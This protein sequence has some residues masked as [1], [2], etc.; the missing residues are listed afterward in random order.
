MVYLRVMNNKK[1]K[2]RNNIIRKKYLWKK[3][4]K[5]VTGY[6]RFIKDC[7]KI[8]KKDKSSGILSLDIE[9]NIFN[10]IQNNNENKHDFIIFSNFWKS[11]DK[12]IIDKYK[13]NK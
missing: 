3:N 12:N 7:Y 6:N 8:K 10:E 11:L 5:Y 2:N 9:K 1:Y 4:K 13:Y